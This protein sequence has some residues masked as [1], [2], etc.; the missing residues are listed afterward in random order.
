MSVSPLRFAVPV[1]YNR[2]MLKRPR[3]RLRRPR[4]SL[5]LMLVCLAILAIAI[6]IYRD[7]LRRRVE[8][9]LARAPKQDKWLEIHGPQTSGL[10]VALG[11]PSPAEVAKAAAVP[12]TATDVRMVVEQLADYA[13]PPEYSPTAGTSRLHHARY[14]SIIFSSDGV[15][16]VYIDHVHRC[17]P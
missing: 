1:R 10:P 12:S 11:P 13:D 15:R 6:A 3:F 14:K 9:L 2:G 16:T 4:Y 5:R 17:V 8:A 7:P